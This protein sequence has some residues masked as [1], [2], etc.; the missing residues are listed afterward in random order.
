MEN[1]RE[2]KRLLAFW[3]KKEKD[4][5]QPKSLKQIEAQKLQEKLESLNREFKILEQKIKEK[6][7]EKTMAELRYEDYRKQAKQRGGLRPIENSSSIS[8]NSHRYGNGAGS[9]SGQS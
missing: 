4:Q 5:K 1:Y 9:K 3:E 2:I 8:V 6:E 7:R